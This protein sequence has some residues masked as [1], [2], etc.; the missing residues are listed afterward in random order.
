M[1]GP[2]YSIHDGT[3]RTSSPSGDSNKVTQGAFHGDWDSTVAKDLESFT[4]ACSDDTAEV[5]TI[6]PSTTRKRRSHHGTKSSEKKRAKGG[7][8]YW[9]SM[10]QERSGALNFILKVAIDSKENKATAL[11][12]VE[13][14][15]STS[16]DPIKKRVIDLIEFLQSRHNTPSREGKSDTNARA[17]L[18]TK[19]ARFIA[20]DLP[21]YQPG[22]PQSQA[23][24]SK[25]LDGMEA[26]RKALE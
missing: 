15:V 21:G 13:A 14:A 8:K 7:T 9:S 25:E 11:E 3:T 2:G 20:R 12:R 26:D 22:M 10:D 6:L 24:L 4:K 1:E 5:E 18:R 23:V 19:V 17:A 16:E